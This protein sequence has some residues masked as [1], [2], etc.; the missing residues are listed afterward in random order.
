[1]PR[2]MHSAACMLVG[3]LPMPG[4]VCSG[5]CACLCSRTLVW[6]SLCLFLL[7]GWGRLLGSVPLVCLH[8]DTHADTHTMV[9]QLL[10]CVLSCAGKR[11]D[12]M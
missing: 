3:A 6:S 7:G 12:L 1:M 10:C 5:V 4:G 11:G 9:C 2:R 8:A